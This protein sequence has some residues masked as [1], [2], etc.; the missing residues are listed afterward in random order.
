MAPTVSMLTALGPYA[1]VIDLGQARVGGANANVSVMGGFA[2]GD[3][4]FN[5]MTVVVTGTDRAAAEALA[6]ELARACWERRDRF[7]ARLTAIPDGLA[8]LAKASPVP[9]AFADVADNPGG[10]GGGNTMEILRAF[11]AAGVERA[12][13]GCIIDPALAGE[14]H[15][16]GGRRRVHRALQPCRRRRF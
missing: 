6:D 12:A 5:G 10:G 9:L 16:L 14:A 8:R 7:V 2:Y 13:F 1:E 4:P 15:A 3:T 11:H